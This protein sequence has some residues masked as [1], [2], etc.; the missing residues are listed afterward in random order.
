M[1]ELGYLKGGL[2]MKRMG[3]REGRSQDKVLIKAQSLILHLQF[4]KGRPQDPSFVSAGLGCKA[5]SVG[6]L[7]F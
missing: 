5:S 7:F 1:D 2:E 6:S 4:I 3:V